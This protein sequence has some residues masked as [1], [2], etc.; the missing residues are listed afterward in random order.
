MLDPDALLAYPSC[1]GFHPPLSSPGE[2]LL[3][4]ACGSLPQWTQSTVM[5]FHCEMVLFRKM[6]TQ[7]KLISFHLFLPSPPSLSSCPTSPDCLKHKYPFQLMILSNFYSHFFLKYPVKS[8]FWLTIAN[9]L[10]NI[11]KHLHT[12]A[13]PF[14]ASHL[15]F[16]EVLRHPIPI[17]KTWKLLHGAF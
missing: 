4:P 10:R 9:A 1:F 14:R 12:Y 5:P 7:N 2:Y 15:Q 17:V 6:K 3:I 16:L 11:T 13:L 8:A